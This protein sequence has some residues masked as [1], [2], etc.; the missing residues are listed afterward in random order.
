MSERV[1]KAQEKAFKI[2]KEK[3]VDKCVSYLIGQMKKCGFSDEEIEETFCRASCRRCGRI[4][5]E[6]KKRRELKI[7]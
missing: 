2:D 3:A 6:M 1:R 5:E 7:A 4:C